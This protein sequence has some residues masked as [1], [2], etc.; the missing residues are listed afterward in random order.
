VLPDGNFILTLGENRTLDNLEQNPNAVF[1]AMKE[2]PVA[3]TTPGWRL[4]LKVRT[5]H[6]EGEV[7]ESARSY[8][9]QRAGSEVAEGLRAAVI[10][11]I[12]EVRPLIDN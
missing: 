11:D 2:S 6:R 7:L 3:F 1:L 5:I 4:Y 12:I 8:I 10:F 9:A